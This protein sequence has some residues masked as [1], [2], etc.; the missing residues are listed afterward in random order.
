[1]KSVLADDGDGLSAQWNFTDSGGKGL[2]LQ[3]SGGV[4]KCRR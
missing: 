3:H 2:R 1:M 4:L